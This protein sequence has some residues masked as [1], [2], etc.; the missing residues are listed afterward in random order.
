M[1]GIPDTLP[2]PRTRGLAMCRSVNSVCSLATATMASNGSSSPWR[3]SYAVSKPF[4]K[5]ATC[6]LLLYAGFVICALT[7]F[8]FFTQA[9][10]KL[11]LSRPSATYSN[12]TCAPA[13]LQLFG[14]PYC[15]SC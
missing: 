6:L 4:S 9:K 15:T 10:T 8:T 3:L 7:V 13:S 1:V 12:S 2:A 14:G 5:T 11:C